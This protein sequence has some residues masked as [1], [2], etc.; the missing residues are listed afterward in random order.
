MRKALA[1]IAVGILA[2]SITAYGYVTYTVNGTSYLFPE[3]NDTVW[4]DLVTD[5]AGAVSNNTL[6]KNGGSFTLTAD[7]DFGSNFGLLAPYY[8][9]KAANVSTVGVLRMGNSESVAWRNV[10]NSGNVSLLPVSDTV[11]GFGGIDLINATN[12]QT[13]Y[14]KTLVTPTIASF[15]N[16]NHDHSD[17]T[18]GGTVS[19]TSLTD[20]GTNTHAA[21][22]THIATNEAH[23][24]NG[25]I[26]G[27][28]DVTGAADGALASLSDHA[29]STSA[30]GLDGV[31]S[32]V[33]ANKGLADGAFATTTDHIAATNAHGVSKV[34]GDT[35]AATLSNKEMDFGPS[36]SNQLKST[37]AN[38]GDIPV[39]NGDGTTTWAAQAAAGGDYTSMLKNLSIQDSVSASTM[40][41]AIRTKTGGNP[42]AGDKVSIAFRDSVAA[43]GAYHVI[44]ITATN[45]LTV[46]QGA[47]LGS[48]ANIEQ[49]LWVYALDTDGSIAKTCISGTLVDDRSLQTSVQI[50]SASDLVTAIYCDAA[51]T[52]RPVRLIGKLKHTQATAGD[53]L[54][55][56]TEVS[57]GLGTRTGI[58]VSGWTS[59]SP[60]GN[61]TSNTTYA[62][63]WRR[64]GEEMEMH[65]KVSLTGAPTSANLTVNL[66]SGY[67]IDSNRIYTDARNY[68]GW[69]STKSGGGNYYPV[70]IGYN[71][72]TS[73]NV[74]LP[75]NSPI[76]LTQP[77]NAT[78]P[79]TY[80][81]EDYV[82]VQCKFPI[83]GWEAYW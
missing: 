48:V 61:W 47:T 70:Y 43:T 79:Q 12:A 65:V 56:A 77:V 46:P 4:G 33:N 28:N 23:G 25:Y 45:E 3:V 5:W 1:Y 22:D 24:S 21:I 42:T 27:I 20:I 57:S 36:G 59:F 71:N 52:S 8:K 38:A 14:N 73:V 17:A 69:G 34:T 55:V 35:D 75:K 30:H 49:V 31:W 66:P 37:G 10:G 81:N 54:A 11:L 19:H 80:A 76:D 78:T 67:T 41:L 2:L 63:R 26:A 40:T 16:A 18:N 32:T 7:T 74:Y 6:Q 39:S 62:G 29:G 53:W 50:S 15:I 82:I 9:S 68:L 83:V 58:A 64:V 44:D 51:Y 72:T 60:T 13:L